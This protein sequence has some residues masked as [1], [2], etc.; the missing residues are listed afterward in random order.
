MAKISRQE[1]LPIS[2]FL[3]ADH[4]FS[5]DSYIF[6]KGIK[7]TKYYFD[8]S[9]YLGWESAGESHAVKRVEWMEL[10]ESNEE[11]SI[12]PKFL[13][14][15]SIVKNGWFV[16][17][18]PQFNHSNKFEFQNILAKIVG[19]RPAPSSELDVRN[20]DFDE[21]YTIIKIYPE[22]GYM[23]VCPSSKFEKLAREEFPISKII[24]LSTSLLTY[25]HDVYL[26]RRV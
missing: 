22:L 21:K 15:E 7:Y 6:N 8:G 10:L 3:E 19:N 4:G 20:F 12:S 17:L 13:D 25:A 2:Y 24:V 26:W 14:Q 9:R 18:N 5:K 11:I 1:E 16:R 23:A